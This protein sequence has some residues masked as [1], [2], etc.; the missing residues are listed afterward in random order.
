MAK[1]LGPVVAV[2][3]GGFSSRIEGV[4]LLESIDAP[5]GPSFD[6]QATPAG[7]DEFA[8]S[9]PIDAAA[10]DP[11][12][13]VFETGA[14]VLALYAEIRAIAASQLADQWAA[15]SLHPTAL[16]NEA[17]MRILQ[18]V[19]GEWWESP[20]HFLGAAA[21]AMRRVIVDAARR[22]KAWKRGGRLSRHEISSL[23]LAAPDLDGE[24]L[25]VDDALAV[26][27]RED[28]IAAEVFGLRYFGG[29]T[30]AE[31]AEKIGMPRR[32]VDRRLAYA[33]AWLACRWDD[34]TPAPPRE[35]GRHGEA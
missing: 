16:A 30:V 7:P 15:N 18:G 8:G 4:D 32:S 31:M 1:T 10:D 33:R 22:R 29:L 2:D 20:R 12:R 19:G 14:L 24:V 26:L 17:V 28:A 11:G 23:G 5:A 35:A 25:F 13:R 21:E 27:A 3:T 34:E 6:D 9:A